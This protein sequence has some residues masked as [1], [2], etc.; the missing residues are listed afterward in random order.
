[1]A[2]LTTSNNITITVPDKLKKLG[3]VG[4]MIFR[5]A[6]LP[7][8][9]R[10]SRLVKPMVTFYPTPGDYNLPG[11]YPKKWYQRLYGPR[12]AL[13]GGGVHGCDTSK[14]L[15]NSWQQEVTKDTLR[16]W[17]DVSYAPYV[18]GMTQTAIHE[19]H[20][21]RSIESI[22][23]EFSGITQEVFMEEI[24]KIIEGIDFSR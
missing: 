17:T 22:G 24:E 3:E 10:V 11:P 16:T 18:V 14:E 13:K 4:T 23:E 19:A 5:D 1:M 7:T 6:T 15:M 21:W 9:E 8:I 12:W 2:T 20:G